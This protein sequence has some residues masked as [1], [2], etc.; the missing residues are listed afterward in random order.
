MTFSREAAGVYKI[1]LEILEGLGGGI[2]LLKNGNSGEVG[3]GVL[4][5][6]PPW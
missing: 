6:F 5:K 1:L 2:F 3:G 4:L